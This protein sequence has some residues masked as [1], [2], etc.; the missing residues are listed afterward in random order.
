MR[1]FLIWG[2]IAGLVAGT[3]DLG[4]ACAISGLAPDVVM[5]FIARGVLGKAA[6][7]GGAPA[8]AL[9]FVLQLVMGV[10]IALIYA[11]AAS[12]LPMLSSRWIL[13]GLAYGVVIFAVMN[14]VVV[15]LSMV[16]AVPHFTQL[17]FVLNLAAMLGFGLIVSYAAH[18]AASTA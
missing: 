12:R 17:K 2:L 14:Y 13:C 9:G 8:A 18:R 11:V 1:A 16:R 4:A 5:R 6:A 15:P 10:M 3:L 7:Q